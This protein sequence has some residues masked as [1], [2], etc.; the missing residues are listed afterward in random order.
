MTNGTTTEQDLAV[1]NQITSIFANIPEIQQLSDADKQKTAEG[2]ILFT[3]FLANDW[4][5]AQQGVEGYDLNAVKTYTKDT[6]VQLGIDSTQFDFTPQGLVRKGTAGQ[7]TQTTQGSTLPQTNDPTTQT[8]T[9]TQTITPN[10][11]TQEQNPLGPTP[12]QNPLNPLD[13][14][15]TDPFASTFNGENISLSLTGT[16]SYSGEL[17]FNGQ[18]YP[19]QAISNGQNLSGTF[20]N[21]G[22]NFD[23][24]ATLQGTTLMLQSGG[25][26]FTLEKSVANPLGN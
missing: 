12:A 5:Q 22:T 23:F 18:P 2:L 10:T 13:T 9:T 4:Q 17:V 20:S 26:S 16:G 8:P 6:L 24:T 25:S 19:V 7:S 14:T 11:T 21:A 15:A 3:I 1:R